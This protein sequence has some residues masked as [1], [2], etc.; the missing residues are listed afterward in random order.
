LG[1]EGSA[2]DAKPSAAL[3]LSDPRNMRVAH[4][5]EQMGSQVEDALLARY[6]GGNQHAK[7]MIIQVL[8][9]VATEKGIAKLREI[10][11]DKS[12]FASAALARMMLRR[13]GVSVGN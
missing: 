12:D 4:C 6:D 9:T 5:L 3:L 1:T 11:A 10:A 2:E 8:G 7:R 13:R